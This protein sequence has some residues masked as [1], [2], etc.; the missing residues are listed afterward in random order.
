MSKNK[1][2]FDE[3][4]T[5]GWSDTI[6]DV[7]TDASGVLLYRDLTDDV[8]FRTYELVDS[9]AEKD[10]YSKSFCDPKLQRTVKITIQAG[11][12]RETIDTTR[13]RGAILT[14]ESK[15]LYSFDLEDDST[16]FLIRINYHEIKSNNVLNGYINDTNSFEGAV[17]YHD[18]QLNFEYIKKFI[19]EGVETIVKNGKGTNDVD[20]NE[21]L[22]IL[23]EYLNT[24]VDDIQK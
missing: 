9:F 16:N 14:I 17:R 21:V 11:N 3:L 12:R 22:Y 19:T 24:V 6:G 8:E 20:V 5:S 23:F 13:Y 7:Y 15:S 1:N 18:I 2:F 10:V 4:D